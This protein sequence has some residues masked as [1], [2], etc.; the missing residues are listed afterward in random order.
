F[1]HALFTGVA[2]LG[3]AYARFG[4]GGWRIAA[5]I[6]GMAGAMLMHGMWN[7]SLVLGHPFWV[8]ALH[9]GAFVGL[10]VLIG[11]YVARERRWML[12]ELTE[13]A[14]YGLVT[15]DEVQRTCSVWRRAGTEIGALFT[16]G[17]GSLRAK[18]RFYR[19]LSE[20]A[21]VKHNLRT[22]GDDK[23]A[24]PEIQ[25]L[26]ARLSTRRARAGR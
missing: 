11:V 3:F 2:G 26:R 23:K 6:L 13:E 22:L 16:G 4:R 5:P 19:D 8:L 20:L 17:P 25:T 12:A 10:M 7:G 1:G 18:E 24:V 14:G 15:A 9:W 21:L